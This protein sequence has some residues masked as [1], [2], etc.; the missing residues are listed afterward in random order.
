MARRNRRTGTKAA[1]PAA[2]LLAAAALAAAACSPKPQQAALD[3]GGYQG[4]ERTTRI[5][6]DYPIPGHESHYRRIYINPVGAEYRRTGNR[7]DYPDGTIVVKEIFEGLEPPEGGR[8]PIS[9]DIMVKDRKA[10]DA[11]GGWRW[12][13]RDMRGGTDTAFTGDFCA[14]CHV[15]ASRP[16]PYGDRNPN[17]EDRDYLFY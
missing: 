10:P 14:V 15:E 2:G 1:P 6:L 5:E 11:R 17:A 3:I 4:W 8:G 7:G 12:I 16:H 13:I 9:L